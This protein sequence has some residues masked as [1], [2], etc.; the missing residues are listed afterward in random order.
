[1]NDRELKEDEIALIYTPGVGLRL[2]LPIDELPVGIKG[3]LLAAIYVRLSQGGEWA[4]ELRRWT[5]AE[6]PAMTMQ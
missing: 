2:E 6:L 5:M 1:M 3:A 4:E